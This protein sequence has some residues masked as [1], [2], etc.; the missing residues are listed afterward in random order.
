LKMGVCNRLRGSVSWIPAPR[1]HEDKLC[2][3]DTRSAGE[4]PAEGLG[5]SPKFLISPQEWGI[6]GV[7][8]TLLR[9]FHQQARE[10]TVPWCVAAAGWPP[11]QGAC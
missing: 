5:V 6:K 2:G 9:G 10:H 4:A 3:N 11:R 1:L 8:R 7:D